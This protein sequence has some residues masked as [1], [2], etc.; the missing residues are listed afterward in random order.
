MKS[1]SS[2]FSKV[3]I[4]GYFFGALILGVS[5]G[6]S[7]YSYWLMDVL[8]VTGR[9]IVFFT[10]AACVAG[11]I[12]YFILLKRYIVPRFS[13]RTV[14]HNGR[15]GAWSVLLGT[16]LFLAGTSSWVLPT[17]YLA[18]L[19]PQ[20]SLEIT[21]HHPVESAEL[22]LVWIT[23]SLGDISYDAISYDGWQ[24]KSD[25]LVLS[26]GDNNSIRWIGRTGGQVT[27]VLLASSPG[28]MV[29]V[30]WGGE[31]ETWELS[32]KGRLTLSHDFH[33]PF[34]ASG[35][36]VMLFGILNFIVITLA[37][38]MAL[39]E[40]KEA[41]LHSLNDSILPATYLPQAAV[42]EPVNASRIT[43][44]DWM[45]LTGVLILALLLRIFNLDGL[46]PYADEYAH[47]L[48]AKDLLNGVSLSD[49]YQRSLMVV[50]WP[51][52]LSFRV[53]GMDLWAARLPG[54]LFNVLAILPLY[55]IMKR[56]NRPVAVLAGLLY[57]TSPWIIAV[58]RNVREYAFYPFYF[59]WL[60]YAMILFV[61]DFPA[62]FVFSDYK[63]L[64]TSRLIALGSVILLPVAYALFIDNM[65]TFKVFLMV[66][67]AFGIVLLSK[68]DLSSRLNRIV[69]GILMIVLLLA[70]YGLMAGGVIAAIQPQF[71]SYPSNYFL[72]NARQ[73]WY[74][75]RSAV[76]PVIAMFGAVLLGL[77]LR[78][79]NFL[80][81]FWVTVLLASIIFFFLFFDHY[82]RPR[83]VLSVEFW[84]IPVLACGLFVFWTGM[85]SFLPSQI[86]RITVLVLL[87]LVSF[88]PSQTLL[89][90][91]YESIGY[92]PITEEYHDDVAHAQSY[93]LDRVDGE[94]VLISTVYGHYV[95]FL[96]APVFRETYPYDRSYK[97]PQGYVRS[98]IQQHESGWI[99]LDDR[100]Y[101]LSKP[102]PLKSIDVDGKTVVFDGIFAGQYIWHWGV[103]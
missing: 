101:L 22:E 61:M 35:T 94:N 64:L 32:K 87:L 6:L 81:A 36:I 14:V 55:L 37:V 26:D 78:R 46:P 93:L 15:L 19:L 41:L 92:M 8:P 42:D 72:F 38:L 25:R 67:P 21:A 2:Y 12:G 80:P 5:V 18:F 82:F 24:R 45:I 50:T 53:F 86:A 27:I 1:N 100:R 103:E 96:G 23:T 52:V 4:V 68:M 57:A 79:R 44:S 58:A 56:I 76:I 84:L 59:Y 62:R 88:N 102:L 99:V 20:Q 90:T 11:T 17:R 77:R 7:L 63:K 49:V 65:S 66:Y 29:D 43:G 69:I 85:R 28:G 33:V 91:L 98:I 3:G 34:Y 97:D 60:V 74:F 89:P 54:V 30:S 95:K 39:D 73:Q 51:V 13:N 47:L 83:Y 40:K 10:A 48:A 75:N 70:I 16:I 9:K 31:R 71:D